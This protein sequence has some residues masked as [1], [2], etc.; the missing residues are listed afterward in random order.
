MTRKRQAPRSVAAVARSGGGWYELDACRTR[1]SRTPNMTAHSSAAATPRARKVSGRF[2]SKARN[3]P[4]ATIRT[5]PATRPTCAGSPRKA[6]ASTAETS[7][8]TPIRI[9][10]R[11]GPASRIEWMK[12]ICDERYEERDGEDHDRT[13]LGVG[14]ADEPGP[15]RD[16][17]E[18]E[19]DPGEDPEEDGEHAG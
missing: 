1:L 7:G 9:A 8:A 3:A 12:R 14:A 5:V 11:E 19:S 4:P 2:P 10:A 6:I 13:D 16:R 18:A 17:Q 15:D